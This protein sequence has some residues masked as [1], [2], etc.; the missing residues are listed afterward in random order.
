MTDS[1]KILQIPI[2]AEAIDALGLKQSGRCSVTITDGK[3]IIEKE[4][5]TSECIFGDDSPECRDCPFSCP[6]CGEC[7]ADICFELLEDYNEERGDED[8]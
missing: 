6:N 5:E 1:M 3:I 4:E 7:I 2:P 8:D